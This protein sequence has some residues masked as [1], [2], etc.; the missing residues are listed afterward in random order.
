MSFASQSVVNLLSAGCGG[1]SGSTAFSLSA[2]LSSMVIQA[3]TTL[4]VASAGVS[5]VADCHSVFHMRMET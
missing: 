2:V 3:A 1:P 5:R 4:E